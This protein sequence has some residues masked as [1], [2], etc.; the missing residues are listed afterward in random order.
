MRGFFGFM[1]R[2]LFEII[3][4]VIIIILL[5][6]AVQSIGLLSSFED[7]KYIAMVRFIENSLKQLQLDQVETWKDYLT[8][9]PV[10]Y[11]ILFNY[12][13]RRIYLY[14]CDSPELKVVFYNITNDY[15]MA[16]DLGGTNCYP[17]YASEEVLDNATIVNIN[18]GFTVEEGTTNTLSVKLYDL[19]YYTSCYSEPGRIGG[20]VGFEG[21]VGYCVSG[22]VI[23]NVYNNVIITNESKITDVSSYLF[24]MSSSI[25]TG[26]RIST[27]CKS[28]DNYLKCIVDAK[29]LLQDGK[30][31]TPKITVSINKTAQNTIINFRTTI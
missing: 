8:Y 31:A 11:S 24:G 1:V 10:K 14:K 30:L 29:Q 4:L 5:V 27:D 17:I 9:N 13:N 12:A 6:Y 26:I 22:L 20:Y 28:V 25:N 19:K 18:G 23:N 15:L 16:K 7:K 21:G 3:V 2:V